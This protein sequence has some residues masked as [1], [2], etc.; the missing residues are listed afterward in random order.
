MGLGTL[1]RSQ[2]RSSWAGIQT[3]ICLK[4]EPK[5]LYVI[6]AGVCGIDFL[7]LPPLELQ[8]AELLKN[9]HQIQP[10]TPV[11]STLPGF[12]GSSYTDAH[13]RWDDALWVS[14]RATY[15]RILIPTKQILP[16]KSSQKPEKL[17]SA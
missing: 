10:L 14:V 8:V 6:P 13:E 1:P 4:P 15:S 7:P 2:V 3:Q 5:F 12:E 9:R 11:E 16:Q 17:K